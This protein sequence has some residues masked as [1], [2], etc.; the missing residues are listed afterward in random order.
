MPAVGEIYKIPYTYKRIKNHY[1]S[2]HMQEAFVEHQA[3]TGQKSHIIKACS[4]VISAVF[5]LLFFS[6]PIFF[7]GVSYQGLIFDKFYLF[8]LLMLIGLVAWVTRG[9]LQGNMKIRRTP[10]DIPLLLFWVWYGIAAIF[11][12]DRWHSFIGSFADPSRGFVAVTFFILTF[13]FIISHATPE[14]VR[15]A[16]KGSILAGFIITLWSTYMLMGAPLLPTSLRSFIPV[17]LLGSISSLAL[18]LALLL[19]L[20][21]TGIFLN[22]EEDSSLKQKVLQW[23]MGI[24]LILILFCLL[25][26]YSFTPWMVVLAMATFFVVYIIAQLV[27]P[28]GKVSWLPMAIFVVILGFLMLGQVN[29]ARVQLPVEVSP[30]TKLSWQ[31]TK[32]ALGEQ[33]LTGAGPANY[34]SVFAQYKPENFN[35]NQLYAMRFG[36]ANNIFLEVFAMAGILG[37]VLFAF[38]WVLF[39][40]SGLYLLTYNS[41]ET[42]KVISLGLWSVVVLFFLSSIFVALGG[43]LLLVFIPLT[44]LAYIVLQ[45][46]TF[47]KD[48]YLQFSLQATPKYALALAF[49]FMVVSAGVI[50]IL[51]FFGK[52]YGA[53]VIVAQGNKA[54]RAGNVEQAVGYYTRSLQLYPQESEYYLR[55]AQAYSAL[56][57]QEAQKGE[58]ADRNK[59]A[60]ALQQALASGEVAAR[61]S[62]NDV[63]TIDAL[64]LLYEDTIRY[65]TDAASRT[66]ELYERSSKLDPLN[67]LYYVKIGE[68]KR[69][70]GDLKEAPAEKT[71]LYRE[72]L[73]LFDQAIEKKQNLA[74]AY[75]QKAITHSRLAEF[76]TAIEEARKANQYEPNNASYAF[77]LGALYDLRNEG[78][79]RNTAVTIYRSILTASPNILDVR[80]ALALV[81][82][83]QGD[84]EGAIKEYQTSL[85]IVKKAEGNTDNLQSQIQKLLDTVRNGG[86]NIPSSDPVTPE[87]PASSEPAPENPSPAPVGAPVP[88]IAPEPSA[89]TSQ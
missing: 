60:G 59:M 32:S 82:E 73:G 44:A 53:D 13:Y 38:V 25:V 12:M 10:I 46:E 6:L 55:L 23:G 80:L 18:Y 29:I 57:A 26:L 52:V 22:A 34:D 74:V 69:Y 61:L 43:A 67:P 87:L 17:S 39:L 19:P 49:T 62:G 40:G 79:D 70:L 71:P 83:K 1:L 42:N 54:L 11:S 20:F 50:Y 28:S 89:A 15:S 21:I 77:T 85:D 86:S 45:K 4:V 41:R 24:T 51:I 48:Q 47:A 36:Q 33:W 75:Y 84:R 88:N 72:A 68:I 16:L 81:L 7:S 8:Y 56:V 9:V 58:E 3:S 78:D 63:A 64:A 37:I 65:A 35:D 66:T 31:I 5:F 2:N 76:D 27:R 30:T 14:R